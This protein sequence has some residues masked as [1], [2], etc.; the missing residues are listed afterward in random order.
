MQTPLPSLIQPAKFKSLMGERFTKSST[1]CIS[2]GQH[3]QDGEASPHHEKTFRNMFEPEEV[4]EWNIPLE[5]LKRT[6]IE[7]LTRISS[8]CIFYIRSPVLIAFGTK[9]YLSDV[10]S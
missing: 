4:M 2:E 8:L 6:A 3:P 7:I 5:Y 9:F 10:L 1:H